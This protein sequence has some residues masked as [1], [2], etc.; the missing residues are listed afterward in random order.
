[1]ILGDV[2]H[3]LIIIINQKL[4]VWI[5]SLTSN[6]DFFLSF[7]SSDMWIL[8]IFSILFYLTRVVLSISSILFHLTH[9]DFEN[10]FHFVSSDTCRFWEYS[11][12]CFIWHTW[13]MRIS[14]ILFHLIHMDFENN[15]HFALSDTR[16]FWHYP[17]FCFIW[18]TWIL[19]ISSMG[20]D[21]L[22]CES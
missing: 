17:P 13:I 21:L 9:V 10:N 22:S 19:R 7:V 20:P 12:F 6:I 16:R 8:R 15:F 4:K 1:M 5:D 18:Y 14:S 11:P 2:N 3:I